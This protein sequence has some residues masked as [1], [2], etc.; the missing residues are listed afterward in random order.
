MLGFGNVFS[1]TFENA[2]VTGKQLRV[3]TDKDLA[4]LVPDI[5]HREAIMRALDSMKFERSSV[6]CTM[7]GRRT[8]TWS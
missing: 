5:S 3:M 8:P 2:K 6:C 4:A 1:A 7:T